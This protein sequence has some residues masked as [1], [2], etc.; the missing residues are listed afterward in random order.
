MKTAHKM[1][2]L[3]AAE[4]HSVELCFGRASLA[5]L[6]TARGLRE[7]VILIWS[8]GAPTAHYMMQW[9]RGIDP[10]RLAEIGSGAARPHLE[11]RT[12]VIDFNSWSGER[13]GSAWRALEDRL[14]AITRATEPTRPPPHRAALVMGL[15]SLAAVGGALTERI[16]NAHHTLDAP[17]DNLV[18]ETPISFDEGQG[19]ALDAIE[20]GL[21]LDDGMLHLAHPAP[22]IAPLAPVEHDALDDAEHAPSMEFAQSNPSVLDRLTSLAAPFRRGDSSAN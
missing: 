20:P 11:R 16:Y 17:P 21:S 6:E 3:L 8:A 13:G 7:A 9:A 18:A 1:M 10:A 2:R 14:R 22:H 19:G 4:Q 12:H 5:Q 15:A